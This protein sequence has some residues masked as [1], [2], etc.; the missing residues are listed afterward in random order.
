MRCNRSS[1]PWHQRWVCF[2][3]RYLYPLDV[4]SPHKGPVLRK[5]FP[6]YDV[7]MIMW[8][9]GTGVGVGVGGGWGGASTSE[10]RDISCEL[11]NL[12]QRCDYILA[13]QVTIQYPPCVSPV[14]ICIMILQCVLLW[15]I[16]AP[17]VQLRRD[18]YIC[19]HDVCN[20]INGV[21]VGNMQWNHGSEVVDAWSP[22]TSITV[23]S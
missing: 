5:M 6:F 3:I 16:R 13:D 7:I 18:I 23:T 20:I 1:M 10:G 19:R 14:K 12:P 4:D 8:S 15:S 2:K 17:Y 9:T 21:Y 22:F 11:K